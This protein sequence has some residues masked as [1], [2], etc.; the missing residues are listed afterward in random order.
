M[1]DKTDCIIAAASGIL[2]GIIDS[3]WVGE[4]SLSDAQDW[5]HSKANLF[6]LKVAQI[7]GY[8]KNDLEGAI[9]YLEKKAPIPSDRKHSSMRIRSD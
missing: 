1:A 7:R 3:F 4:F 2:T 5:G 6:V 9:R 8:G